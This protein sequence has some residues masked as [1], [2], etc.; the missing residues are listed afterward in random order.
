MKLNL[1]CGDTPI[2]GW[3][4]VDLFPGPDVQQIVD[5]NNQ[6]PWDNSS[7]EAVRAWH[8]FEHL[9][10]QIHS[11]NELWRVLAPAAVAEIQL[12]TT[13]SF[14]AFASPTHVSYWHRRTFLHFEAGTAHR[15]R[16]GDRDGIIARFRTIDECVQDT[17]DGE[18]LA[19]WLMAVK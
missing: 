16:W 5:L 19:I 11:M 17:P 8:I 18:N 4:N 7:V 12:P 14:G 2:A 3:H 6:W 10:S 1:G 9:R 15:E 13:D